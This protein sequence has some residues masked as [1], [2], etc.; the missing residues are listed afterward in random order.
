MQYG[1]FGYHYGD[2]TI[3]IPGLTTDTNFKTFEEIR[4][5]ELIEKIADR[6]LKKI[7]EEFRQN[8]DHYEVPQTTSG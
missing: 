2:L 8:L 6:V 5:E 3:G 4:E 1:N 7:K